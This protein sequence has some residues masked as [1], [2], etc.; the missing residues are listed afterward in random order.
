[1]GGKPKDFCS[2]ISGTLDWHPSASIFSGAGV[3]EGGALFSYQANW[4]SPGRWA[5]ELLTQNNRLI[6]RPLE[7]LQIQRKGSNNID[8]VECDYSLDEL[9]KPGLFVQTKTFLNGGDGLCNIFYQLQMMS[10]YEKISG[11]YIPH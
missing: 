8:F 1:L 3:C 6:L 7:K 9:F 11:Y 10:V 4:E 5:V 2:F